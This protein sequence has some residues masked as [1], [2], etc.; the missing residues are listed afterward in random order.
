M[1]IR[2]I[3]SLLRHLMLAGHRRENAHLDHTGRQH[4]SIDNAQRRS[5]EVVRGVVEMGYRSLIAITFTIG[6]IGFASANNRVDFTVNE[7]ISVAGV[8]PVTLGPGSYVLR[9]TDRSGSARVVQILSKGQ[10]YVYTTVLTIAAS[11]PHADDKVQIL[12]S[13]TPSGI[14]PTLHYWFPHGDTLGYEFINPSAF[15]T[16]ERG[17]APRQQQWWTDVSQNHPAQ[18]EESPADFYALKEV[19]TQIESGKFGKARDSFRRNYFLEQNREGATTS[20]LLALLM[21][22]RDEARRTLEVVKRLDPE[23]MRVISRLDVYGVVE[24]LPSERSNLKTSRVRRFL[25]DLALEMI[26]DGLARTAVLSFERHTLRGDSFPVE[27]ALDRRREEREQERRHQEQWVLA[28]E[29]IARLNDCVKSLLNQVGAL[30]YSS[31][32]EATLSLSGSV[33]LRVVLNQRRLNDL[34]AIVVRSHRTI[35]DRHAKL[36]LYISQRNA[37]I[38]RE[39]DSLRSALRELDR[40]PGSPTRSQFS[41]LRKWES[42]PASGVSRDLMTLAETATLPNM[43]PSS[44][45]LA[46]GGY[47][48]MN[49]AASLARLAEWAAFER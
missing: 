1:K 34:D 7:P 3:A 24:S 43:R 41:S 28:K 44:V 19:I 45:L 22:D 30:E 17:T 36:E 40:Q 29:Q 32:V 5:A 2:W 20:F 25:L 31:R 21:S 27:M 18:A 9:T 33:R 8:P 35:C 15:P 47:V 4:A 39:L 11:R 10:D 46:D 26:D 14:P 16:P 13:E 23:R 6:T 37:A 48:Q 12:F 49:I 42:A 38:S